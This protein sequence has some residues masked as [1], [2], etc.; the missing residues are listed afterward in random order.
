MDA[1][2]MQVAEPR[3]T[4]LDQS[5][6][7][8][9]PESATCERNMRARARPAAG[10]RARDRRRCSALAFITRRTSTGSSFVVRAADMQGGAR[11]ASPISTRRRVTE[12]EIAIPTRRGPMRRAAVRAGRQRAPRGAAGVGA[13]SIRHRRAAARRARAPDRRQPTSPSSRRTF[14]SSRASRSRRRSPT[15]SSDAAHLARR[16]MPALAPDH[17]AAADGHQLQRRP[18]DR[19]RGPAI[20]ADRVAYVFSFGGHDD[21]AA[22]AALSVHRTRAATGPT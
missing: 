16:P 10:D 8:S 15:P 9:A 18:V 17:R 4:G 5:D 21:L 2:L 19:R 22:R 3:R 11:G 13:P 6:L 12:R 20:A 1:D 7:Q 14:R